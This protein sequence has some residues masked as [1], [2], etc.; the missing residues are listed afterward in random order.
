MIIG[1]RS[2]QLKNQ[3]NQLMTNYFTR[4]AKI[5]NWDRFFLKIRKFFIEFEL[6]TRLV[7]LLASFLRRWRQRLV[8]FSF[9]YRRRSEKNPFKM[10]ILIKD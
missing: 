8:Q 4:D 6:K 2:G 1:D 5:V 10:L 3:D 9:V 7:Q